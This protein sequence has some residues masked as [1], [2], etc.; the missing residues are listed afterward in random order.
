M[1]LRR[2]V[3]RLFW[4]SILPLL[5]LGVILIVV[6]VQTH[7]A[8]RQMVAEAVVRTAARAVEQDLEVQL[9]SLTMLA[10]LLEEEARH[11]RGRWDLVK[12]RRMML[13]Y[14]AQQGHHVLLESAGGPVLVNTRLPDREA[15]PAR[16]AARCPSSG[17]RFGGPSRKPIWSLW[18]FL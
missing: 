6:Q 8:R 15:A 5:V 4:L 2:F 1:T 11:D 18:P 3:E 16:S 17:M 12:A 9:A 13:Q 7:D 10:R 14:V